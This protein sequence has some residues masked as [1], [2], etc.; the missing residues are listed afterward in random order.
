LRL[1]W[2]DLSNARAVSADGATVEIEGFP[3]AVLSSA[4]ASHFILT[5]EPGCCP[6]CFPSDR[7]A[8]V[9]VFAAAPI[10]IR[11]QKLRLC[12]RWRVQQDDLEGWRYQLLGA[13]LL[14]PPGW[15]SVSR[16]GVL[17]AGPLMC[18]A[19]CAGAPTSSQQ[20]YDARRAIE[21]ATTVD[22]H[23]HA[24]VVASTR[25][26]RNG[27]PFGLVSQPM[28]QGGM[29]AVCLAVVSDGPTH[30]VMSDGRIHPYRQPEPGEL[31][32]YGQLAF[33]RVHDLARDQGMAVIRD[34]AGLQAARAGTASVII[35]AEGA[36]FLEGQV[37]RVDEAYAKW[38]LRHLQLTHY[39]VNE[40]GDIQTEPP[41]HGGLTNFGADV[42]RRCNR[43]GIVVDVAHGTYD[44]VVRAAS[45]TSKPLVLSHT[46][47]SN[48]PSNY[49]RR[50]SPAHA[51][52]IASTGGVIGV[53][54]PAAEFPSFTAMATGMAR[55]V[56]AVGIDHVGLGSDM[57][58]LVGPSILPDYDQLPG[59]AE[60]LIGVG[61]SVS[62]TAKV[63][64][65]NY[66]RVFAACM[67]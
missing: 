29:T 23:S 45:V 8:S 24:G 61:F 38:A 4:H 36:D 11:G 52:V 42:I 28:R 14:E 49:S 34:T 65:G 12:G 2:H 57:M 55:M 46:A 18:L 39:R 41:I 31:Y 63:L 19:A 17:A 22:I 47:L 32:E 40:L 3:V 51:R 67:A 26:I 7:T 53:W 60:A 15:R 66:A 35:A 43:L 64:G 58:G 21:A 44:L 1:N 54:P 50:I 59:L 10:P 9:E 30:R 56:D 62:D 25:R 13:R 5:F 37:D 6:G 16:R 20:Q 48:N 33:R 27:G